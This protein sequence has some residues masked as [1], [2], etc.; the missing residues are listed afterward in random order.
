M[1][2]ATNMSREAR[3][4]NGSWLNTLG[5]LPFETISL[6]RE[7]NNVARKDIE[8]PEGI[9]GTRMIDGKGGYITSESQKNW[10]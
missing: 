9:D 7:R 5:D 4:C 8:E 1:K 2:W 3:H 6:S 10:K